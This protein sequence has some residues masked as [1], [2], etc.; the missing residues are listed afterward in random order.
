MKPNI[1]F[2]PTIEYAELT[3][4]ESEYLMHNEHGLC[5]CISCEIFRE[6]IR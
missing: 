4:E 6:Q 2:E 3:P 5:G 1:E